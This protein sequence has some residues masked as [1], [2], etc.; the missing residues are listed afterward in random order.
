MTGQAPISTDI[1]IIGAGPAGLMAAERL[2]ALG[3][4][5]HVFDAMATPGRK[6]LMAGRGGLN[7][8]H[9][10]PTPGF[11]GRYGPRAG[12]VA[13]WLA[14]FTPADLRAWADELGAETFVG[15]SG[16]VFPKAMKASGLLRAWLRRL[17][18]AGVV[19]HLRHRWTGFENGALRF[20]NGDGDALHVAARATILALGG[21]SWPKLGSDAAWVPLLTERGAAV[22]PFRPANCGFEIEWSAHFRD[23]AAGTPLKN[24]R[25]A[26]GGTNVAGELVITRHGIEGGAV[27]AI[28]AAIRDALEARAPT[29]VHLDLKPQRRSEDLARALAARRGGRSLSATLSGDLKLSPLA[30]PLL[31]EVADPLPEAPAALAAL[32][33][34]VPL[35]IQRPRPIAEAIS[36]AGGLDLAALDDRLMLH[37]L[38]GVFAA[39][40]MLDWEAPTGGYLLQACFSSAVVAADGAAAWLGVKS[41][42]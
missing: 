24:I 6:F 2:A 10:E 32:I 9:S 11:V 34:A 14:R 41:A 37:A 3:F 27:Y 16:R 23:R 39:G 12:T 35:R 42:A 13:A 26:I 22:T 25:L 15:S 1:A 21:A 33:K 36:A 28:G 17:D 29:T 38:P 40:E 8:T 19:F 18:A 5:V 4:S 7:L 20:S 31:R 30:Y